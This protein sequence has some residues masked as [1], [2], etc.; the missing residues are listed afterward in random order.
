M[1]IVGLGNPGAQYAATRH[2]VGFDVV[3]VLAN[4][5]QSAWQT[6]RK[7]QSEV[8]KGTLNGRAVYLLKPQ[9]Y[10]NLSGRAVVPFLAYYKIPLTHLLV[11]V[12][13][14][15]LPLGALRIRPKGSA[16]GQNGMKSIIA[17]L[18]QQ[19]GFARLRVGIGP[20]P[21]QM[22]LEA[23]VLQAFSRPQRDLLEQA[24]LPTA[25]DCVVCWLTEGVEAA[26]N[27]YNGL[28]LS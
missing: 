8:A 25:A 3:T 7:H 4:R 5:M 28:A 9:T 10:M 23:F 19:E 1:C 18:G 20:Q 24:V 6:D 11:V 16:G 27:R 17:T 21:P 15:V 13:E 2:N 22:P 14:V 26:R 12:D